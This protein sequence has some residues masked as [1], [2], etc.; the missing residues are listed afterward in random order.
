MPGRPDADGDHQ[1]RLLDT[2]WDATQQHWN[3][4]MSRH[5]DQRYWVPLRDE[6]R[7]Y[8]QALRKMM[9]LLNAAER[10]TEY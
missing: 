3:D 2:A 6:T 4:D 5:F 8:L 9:D 1:F 7:D 10:D